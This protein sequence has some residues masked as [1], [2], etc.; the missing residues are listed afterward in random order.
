MNKYYIKK[1]GKQELGSP[2]LDGTIARG[3]YFLISKKG[4]DFFPPLTETELN[5]TILIPI[6]TPE[7]KEKVYCSF[8][9]HNSKYHTDKFTGQP[10]DEYRLYMNSGIDP[11]RKYFRPDDIVVFTK[12]Q[13]EELIPIYELFLFRQKNKKYNKLL[14]IIKKSS[15]RGNHALYDKSLDF[16]S[17]TP[18]A[19]NIVT[20]IPDE[21]K[22]V[23]I[24]KQKEAKAIEVSK[25][26][27][28]QK[29]GANLFNSVSFRDFVLFGYE[30]KC[31]ITNTAIYYDALINLEAAHIKPKSHFGSFLPCNG[32]AMSRD[33][34]WAFDKGM[35]TITD[36]FEVLVHEDVKN[37]I[38]NDYN[39]K[40]ISLP[41]DDFFKPEIK[42]LK[43]H[44]EKVFGMFKHSGMIRAIK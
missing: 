28:E 19:E 25:D 31:A 20:V 39:N 13:T 42:Y 32:I 44:R 35:F 36:D 17:Q 24:E 37:T 22:K 27:V 15:L 21:I 5:N 18:I 38:L 8:V 14:N 10:R 40:K 4:G 2:K 43:Y 23:V 9:Y 12:H 16:I 3:R 1:L 33:I 26:N 41:K 7:T 11:E 6:I 30:N 34:H 29:R